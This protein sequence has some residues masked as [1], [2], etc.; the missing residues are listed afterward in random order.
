LLRSLSNL[1]VNNFFDKN[2]PKELIDLID[3][4]LPYFIY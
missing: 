3:Y 4:S 2:S 1:I